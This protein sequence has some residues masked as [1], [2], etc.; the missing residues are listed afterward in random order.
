M[1]YTQEKFFL[2]IASIASSGLSALGAIM[3]DSEALRYVYLTFSVCIIT[4]AFLA[5]VFR[6]PTETMRTVI[7]RCGL[8]ILAG[9]FGTRILMHHV[10]LSAANGDIIYL[11]GIASGVTIAGFLVGYVLL[12][13]IEKRSS[14]IANSIFNRIA[15]TSGVDIDSDPKP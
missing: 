12:R 13:V 7:G 8:A 11:L 1:N 5:L 6:K 10:D 3:A 14:D 4:A 2:G 9:V 15:K